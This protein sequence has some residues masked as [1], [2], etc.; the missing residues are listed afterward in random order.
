MIK[1]IEKHRVVMIFCISTLYI[2]LY[3]L[4]FMNYT[5]IFNLA[6]EIGDIFY[7][8]SIALMT[9]T[10]FYYYIVYL[11]EQSSK[12]K[13]EAVINNR[14]LHLEAMSSIIYNDICLKSTY[15]N[16]PRELPDFTVFTA[17]CSNIKLR[18]LPS[19]YWNGNM[20][21]F[22]NWFEYFQ[23][24]FLLDKSSIDLLFNYSQFINEG[25]LAKFNNVMHTTFHSGITQYRDSNEPYANELSALA[26][27]LLN[28]L[29]ILDSFKQNSWK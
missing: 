18:D 16:I 2:L 27:A 19:P 17:I 4:W 15:H 1:F 25:T 7:N 12:K 21:Q 22:N 13:V 3:K 10:I 14:L 9:S 23:Y 6:F 8:I 28:Y 26:G 29:N 5:E 11:K 20:I 24:T